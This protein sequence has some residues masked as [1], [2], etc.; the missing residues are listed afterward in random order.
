LYNS[1]NA[2]SKHLAFCKCVCKI[3]ENF[4]VSNETLY[5]FKH[6]TDKMLLPLGNYF[7][8]WPLFKRE[9]CNSILFVSFAIES[10]F[11]AQFW[12]VLTYEK[13]SFTPYKDRCSRLFFFYS[14]AAFPFR[15]GTGATNAVPGGS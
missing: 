7:A 11:R 12:F 9:S 15:S 1:F 6:A 4:L 5:R 10:L 2:C 3:L 13:I 8:L 14:D